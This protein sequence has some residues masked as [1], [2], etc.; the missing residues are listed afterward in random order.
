[1]GNRCNDD[2]RG[3]PV[4]CRARE[5]MEYPRLYDCNHYAEYSYD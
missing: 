5:V 1:M 4:G 2:I 3:S